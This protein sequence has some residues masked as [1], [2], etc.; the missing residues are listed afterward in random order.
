MELTLRNE[1]P[2]TVEAVLTGRA[3][4]ASVDQWDTRF[5]A[6]F[7]PSNRNVLVDLTGITF[8]ASLGIRML[9]TAAKTAKAKKLTMVLCVA[10]GPVLDVLRQAAIDRLIETHASLAAARAALPSAP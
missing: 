6:A 8:I 7:A 9:I 1:T 4:S 5:Y 3:D 10:P 2:T